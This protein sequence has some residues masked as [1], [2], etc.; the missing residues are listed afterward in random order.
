[1]RAL[2][3]T[4][5]SNESNGWAQIYKCLIKKENYKWKK[6]INQLNAKLH[7]ID[8]EKM[9]GRLVVQYG[10]DANSS[11]QD[12]KYVKPN[13]SSVVITSHYS[14]LYFIPHTWYVLR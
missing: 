6:E 8:I 14:H 13:S 1:M 10:D 11:T 12:N 4:S 7:H 9:K 3:S 2:S 5:N